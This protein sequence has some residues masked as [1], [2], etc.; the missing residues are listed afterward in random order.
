MRIN[1]SLV[2]EGGKA[3]KDRRIGWPI[4]EEEQVEGSSVTKRREWQK[5]GVITRAGGQ[6]SDVTGREE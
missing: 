2:E 5:K 1:C 6:C 3:E 4:V